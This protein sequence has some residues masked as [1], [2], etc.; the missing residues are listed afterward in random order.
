MTFEEACSY[1]D[2]TPKFTKKHSLDHTR[3]CLRRL[4]NPEKAFSVIHVAGTNGKG[5]VCA[6]LDS[7]LRTAGYR[8]GLFTS[9]HLVDI[10]E[11]FMVAGEMIS[12]EE[13]LAAFEKVLEL[14][15]EMEKEGEGHPTYFEMLFLMGMLIFK[16][17]GAEIVVLETG[18]G[19]RL[20]ATTAVPNPLVCVITSV[21]LDHVQYLGNTVEQI[22]AEKAGI[23]VPG[24]PVVYDANDPKAA[25]VISN[26]ASRAGSRSVPVKVSDTIV[27]KKSRA[28]IDFSLNNDYYDKNTLFH[29]PFIADYQV[30]NAALAVR[31]LEVLTGCGQ[32]SVSREDVIGGIANTSWPGRMET[33]LPGVILDGAHNEDGIRKFA[34]TAEYFTGD[35]SISL[36]FGAV[37]DKDYPDMIGLIAGKIRPE[38]V[39]TTQIGGAREVPAAELAQLF[40]ENGCA[41]V[42]AEPDPKK[43]FRLAL[44]KKQEDGLLF[45]V[46]SLYLVGEIKKE[47][48]A[49]NDRLRRRTEE[50]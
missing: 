26:I 43:A 29:I 44:Q 7:V 4:G 37:N 28:G 23:I 10:R 34:E 39:V 16:D 6:F 33:V 5:S 31:T 27:K 48:A 50:I 30:M 18:L 17:K 15:L 25:E 35:F 42:T 3:E 8:T 36:L 14:S 41:D 12:R 24:V 47:V 40:R 49:L 1:I 21:S 45:C 11:R 2:E 9:P 22:A 20:D 19:G 46:G 13:F 38:S 32:I